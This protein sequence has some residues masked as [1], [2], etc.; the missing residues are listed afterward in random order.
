MKDKETEQ[1]TDRDEKGQ[2]LPGN[3]YLRTSGGL[4]GSSG[5][6]IYTLGTPIINLYLVVTVRSLLN[7]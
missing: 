3:Q 7:K 4:V 6:C 1:Q 5:G 2:F